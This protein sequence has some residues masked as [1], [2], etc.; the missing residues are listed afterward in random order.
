MGAALEHISGS[1]GNSA[2]LT[3]LT[4]ATGDT[5]TIRATTDPTKN[6]WLISAWAAV[7]AAFIAEIHSPRMHD[8][9][10]GIRLRGP[11]NNTQPEWSLYHP[12]KMYTLDTLIVQLAGTSGAASVSPMSLLIYYEDLPGAQARLTTIDDTKRRGINLM[13]QEV[14]AVG[15]ATG[16][17][18]VAVALNSTFDFTKANVDYA[19][20]GFTFD[21][22]GGAVCLRGI[23]TGNL[24]VACP[25]VQ[26]DPQI[27]AEWFPR[28]TNRTGLPC[29]PVINGNNKGG[30]LIDTV[31]NHNAGTMNI[32]V[33]LLE[34]AKA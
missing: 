28:L 22:A 17:Y 10:H 16:T 31:M 32:Q 5:L 26:T 3:N 21:I 7:E 33:H 2:A 24:R 4:M 29:I 18:N 30:V 14:V 15:V 12:T 11:A 9:V 34:L 20:L 8:N 1:I 6:I 25:A 13:C 27:T 23:D 19:L